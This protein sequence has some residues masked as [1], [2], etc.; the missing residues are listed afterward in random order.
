M[1]EGAASS[2]PLRHVW[3]LHTSLLSIA[4]WLEFTHIAIPVGKEGTEKH[5]CPLVLFPVR[6]EDGYRG[7][8]CS[9]LNTSTS[10]L[11]NAFYKNIP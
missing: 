10:F 11:K 7:S 9:P 6:K 1:E 3:Q 8:T 5:A 2:F 4:H